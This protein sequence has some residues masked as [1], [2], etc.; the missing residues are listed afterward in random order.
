[1]AEPEKIGRTVSV[2]R[3][4]LTDDQGELV[5]SGQFTF[6]MTGPLNEDLLKE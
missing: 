5:A 6:F 2:F 3:C 1:V 4:A